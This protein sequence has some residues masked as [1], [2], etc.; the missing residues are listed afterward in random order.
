[1]TKITIYAETSAACRALED[2]VSRE[3]GIEV[4][5][6]VA[7]PPSSLQN[8]TES[9]VLLVSRGLPHRVILHLLGRLWSSNHPPH[10]VFLDMHRDVSDAHPVTVEPASAARIVE[11]VRQAVRGV[12]SGRLAVRFVA[13]R[14]G[15]MPLRLGPDPLD[16]EEIQSAIVA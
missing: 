16:D 14:R 6:A 10:V 7:G 12:A 5:A 2:A 8:F 11:R 3:D 1:M 13:E 9:D 15:P 4:R